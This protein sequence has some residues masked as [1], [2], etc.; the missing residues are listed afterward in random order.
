MLLVLSFSDCSCTECDVNRGRPV[1]KRNILELTNLPLEG[2]F[3]AL[4]AP[5]GGLR[6]RKENASLQSTKLCISMFSDKP[7]LCPSALALLIVLLE[8]IEAFS[9]FLASEAAI[10]SFFRLCNSGFFFNFFFFL[11][12]LLAFLFPPVPLLF[13]LLFLLS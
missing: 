13:L 9:S 6:T 10:F 5:L 2:Y 3:Q 11:S 7:P 12:L 8:A 4:Y 1:I